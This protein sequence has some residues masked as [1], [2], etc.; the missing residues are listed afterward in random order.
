MLA[1]V[2]DFFNYGRT[3]GKTT[4]DGNNFY[5]NFEYPKVRLIESSN[6]QA[7]GEPFTENIII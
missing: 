3:D 6:S 1:S 5:K 4:F 7:N 2:P